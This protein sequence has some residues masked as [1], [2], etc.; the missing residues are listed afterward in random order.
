MGEK[1]KYP[2]CCRNTWKIL[3]IH[4]CVKVCVM[5]ASLKV[6]YERQKRLLVIVHLFFSKR[7][8]RGCFNVEAKYSDIWTFRIWKKFKRKVRQNRPEVWNTLF[9]VYSQFWRF[10]DW[11]QFYTVRANIGIFGQKLS[12]IRNQIFKVEKTRRVKKFVKFRGSQK[13]KS[14]LSFDLIKS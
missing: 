8:I 3:S 9:F 7:P 14:L 10:S 4:R 6:L 2:F 5:C 13:L 12:I 11:K 1:V